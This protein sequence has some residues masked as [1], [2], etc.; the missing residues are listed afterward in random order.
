[1]DYQIGYAV[2]DLEWCQF[3]AVSYCVGEAVLHCP[4][5]YAHRAGDTLSLLVSTLATTRFHLCEDFLTKTVYVVITDCKRP[6]QP[7]ESCT[8][9]FA[10][11]DN[12]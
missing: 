11:C 7:L 4:A 9:G 5:L 3:D 6:F 12:E 10:I 1:M 2:P 8:I